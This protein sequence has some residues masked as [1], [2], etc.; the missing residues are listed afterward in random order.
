MISES[1]SLLFVDQQE[2]MFHDFEYPLGSLLQATEKVEFVFFTN[3]G[4]GVKFHSE[5]PFTQSL[6]MPGGA[7]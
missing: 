5:F 1:I 6:F 2:V 4:F 7:E 3:T